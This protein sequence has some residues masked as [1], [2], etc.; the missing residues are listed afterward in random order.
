MVSGPVKK[1]HNLGGGEPR[2]RGAVAESSD[3]LRPPLYERERKP[4]EE[5]VKRKGGGDK[6]VRMAGAMDEALERMRTV[7]QLI[8]HYKKDRVFDCAPESWD[9]LLNEIASVAGVLK[10]GL[11]AR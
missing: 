3:P 9:P 1:G 10:I 2:K 7:Y 5:P 4:V 11:K 6:W 8:D